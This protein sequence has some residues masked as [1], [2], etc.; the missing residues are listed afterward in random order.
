[1]GLIRI[2]ILLLAVIGCL[3]VTSA[4]NCKS[5]DCQ[6]ENDLQFQEEGTTEE[7]KSRVEEGRLVSKKK[8]CRSPMCWFRAGK[9]EYVRSLKRRLEAT[10][11][12]KRSCSSPMC[13]F[14]P[15]GKRQEIVETQSKRLFNSATYGEKVLNE[16][17]RR[18]KTKIY[19]RLSKTGC[20][21]PMC[22]F[23]AGREIIRKKHFFSNHQQ[24]DS[25]R[26]MG[27]IEKSKIGA[28]DDG[29]AV[30]RRHLDN[31][32]KY[33]EEAMHAGSELSKTDAAAED[34]QLT[35]YRLPSSLRELL[36]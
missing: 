2:A 23:R 36:N 31:Q 11:Q 3:G 32:G 7:I 15:N 13:W 35:R 29:K 26:K 1:M 34:L 9:R 12:R 6:P 5:T 27:I 28:S 25:G 8:A 20:R 24:T 18:I 4:I 17:K 21:S 22:W 14:R 10:R 16:A 19:K 30:F 33:Q